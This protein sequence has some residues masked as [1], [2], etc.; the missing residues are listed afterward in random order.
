[1][2]IWVQSQR[3]LCGVCGG[4]SHVGT[5]VPLST[6]D[7]HHHLQWFSVIAYN[8]SIAALSSAADAVYQ[9]MTDFCWVRS[10]TVFYSQVCR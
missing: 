2:V 3:K 5:D 8:I 10:R 1:M 9:G 6:L 4:H 7:C